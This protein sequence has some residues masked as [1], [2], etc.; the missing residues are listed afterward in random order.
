MFKID[1]F[2]I[3]ISFFLHFLFSKG[4]KY[5][6]FIFCYFFHANLHVGQTPAA[7]H[8]RRGLCLYAVNTRAAGRSPKR[9]P[10]LAAGIK[11]DAPINGK[12]FADGRRSP[13]CAED[14]HQKTFCRTRRN[15]FLLFLF[16]AVPGACGTR[17]GK[18]QSK[19]NFCILLYGLWNFLQTC[20]PSSSV[21]SL[22]NCLSADFQGSNHPAHKNHRGTHC[23]LPP[24]YYESCT[25]P[26]AHRIP[27]AVP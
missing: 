25:L 17:R 16:P 12:L 11:K 13:S 20:S 26:S 14:R 21:Q 9:N 4:K 2:L 15:N 3:G 19:N 27:A 23:H 24:Q 7:S 6:I 22:E 8:C 5:T 10:G 1:D 18:S